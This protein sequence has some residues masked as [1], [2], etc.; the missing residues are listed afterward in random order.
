MEKEKDASPEKEEKEE[1]SKIQ[2]ARFL[3]VSKLLLFVCLGVL[4]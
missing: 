4:S 2:V 3:G 1:T